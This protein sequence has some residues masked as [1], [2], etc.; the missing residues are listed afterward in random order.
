QGNDEM[1]RRVYELLYI[2]KSLPSII[3]IQLSEL[4]RIRIF[5]DIEMKWKSASM[6]SWDLP[7]KTRDYYWKYYY[8]I[9]QNMYYLF[10][11]MLLLKDKCDSLGIEFYVFDGICDINLHCLS[12]IRD[13]DDKQILLNLYQSIKDKNFLLYNGDYSWNQIKS[14]EKVFK[15]GHELFWKDRSGH[16][17]DGEWSL[18]EDHPTKESHEFM[19]NELYNFIKELK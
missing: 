2:T 6:A 19:A 7:K 1:F 14:N 9:Y 5:D 18:D 8:S 11:Q 16:P 15:E 4:A 13:G 12:L 17:K 3:V 10:V